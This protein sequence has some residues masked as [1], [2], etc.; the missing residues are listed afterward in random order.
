M[1]NPSINLDQSSEVLRQQLETSLNKV[2][3]QKNRIKRTNVWYGMASLI[4]SALATFITG[5]A[6]LSSGKKSAESWRLVCLSASV[7]AL[8]A[9]IVAGMQ[10]QL[11]EPE[12][13]IQT[14][15]CVA[16]LKALKVKMISPEWDLKIAT[17]QYQQILEKFPNIDC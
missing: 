3:K 17:E 10:K 6:A 15:E 14:G 13:L 4:L 2:E 12:M 5:Q 1:A 8:G 7:C 16:R 9:T 11:V